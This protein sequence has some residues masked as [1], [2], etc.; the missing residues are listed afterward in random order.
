MSMT[1]LLSS[2]QLVALRRKASSLI[3]N[4]TGE[5]APYFHINPQILSRQRLRRRMLD[6][7]AYKMLYMSAPQ[8]SGRVFREC[9]AR[10]A[11][12]IDN[13]IEENLA[14]I[15]EVRMQVAADSAEMRVEPLVVTR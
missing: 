7:I 3:G 12:V 4:L 6:V 8:D 5:N 10:H 11:S 1:T 14:L 2:D 15:A 13:F 9:C